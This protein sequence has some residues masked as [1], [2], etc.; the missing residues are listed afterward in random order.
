MRKVVAKVLF[1]GHKNLYLYLS[2]TYYI[3]K[4]LYARAS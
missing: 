2:A 3:I 4:Y 1:N